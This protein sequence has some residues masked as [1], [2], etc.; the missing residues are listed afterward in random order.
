M[1]GQTISHYRVGEALGAGGM[2]VVYRAEDVRLNR[3]VALKFLPPERTTDRQALLRLQREARAASA[4]NHPNICTIY[5]IGE[6]NGSQ[7]IA[8][9]LLQGKALDRQI[10][11]RPLEIGVLLELGI[12]IADALEMAHSSGILHRDIKPANIFV[13]ARG[14][15]KILDFGLAKLAP[16]GPGAGVSG[17][18]AATSTLDRELVTTQGVAVGTIAYMSP[19]QARGEDLDART[20]LFSFGVVLYEMA[21]GHQ[22]FGGS[23]SAMVFDAILNREPK[24][25]AELNGD[26]PA[27]LERIIATALEKDRRFRYQ[28]ASDLRADLERL[29]RD[30]ESGRIASR[31]PAWA[32]VQAASHSS[33]G[34]SA[35]V[36]AATVPSWGVQWRWPDLAAV[37][38]VVCLVAAGI[39]FF[40]SRT[41]PALPPTQPAAV[42]APA[43]PSPIPASAAAVV[44]PATIPPSTVSLAT[45]PLDAVPPATDPPQA[46]S[47]PTEATA[48]GLAPGRALVAPATTSANAPA[49]TTARG[50]DPTVGLLDIARAKFETKLYDQALVDLKGIVGRQPSTSSAPGAYLLIGRVYEAQGRTDDAMAAYVELRNRF[51]SHPAAAEGGFLMAGV[52]LRS[53]RSDREAAARAMLGDIPTQFPMSPWAPRA[54]ALKASLEE[55]AELRTVDPQLNASVPAALVSYRTLAERYPDA[56][57]VETALWRISEMY[58]DLRRYDLAAQALDDLAARFPNNVRDAAW[59]AGEVYERRLRNMD[60]A[61]AAYARVPPSSSHYKDAQRR[62]Q[63]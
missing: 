12:Q 62:A 3:P 51:R 10:A 54:L 58:E 28:H 24:S 42:G 27:D 15:A 59:R 1:V 35:S 6:H 19:E 63:R 26:V 49:P 17:S 9:E 25:P 16:S 20:D 45:A 36:S 48:P 32:T 47:A 2:G 30:R 44:P 50:G 56:D 8:M 23:T 37:G 52:L 55:R 41:G 60:K 7:F 33:S 13:T 31:A 57:G 4:L 29:K 39:L 40:E 46:S 43:V 11:G 22:T 53:R 21:T 38:S 14:Q 18:S 5:E 61:R 34:P